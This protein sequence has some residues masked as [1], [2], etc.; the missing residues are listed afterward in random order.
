VIAPSRRPAHQGWCERS[1][2]ASAHRSFAFLAPAL[3]PF[4]AQNLARDLTMSSTE[5]NIASATAREASRPYR[6]GITAG[7]TG[8]SATQKPL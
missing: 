7:L 1:P 6:F 4:T 2:A 3:S 8:K 5:S